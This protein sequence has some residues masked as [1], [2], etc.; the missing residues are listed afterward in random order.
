MRVFG[1]CWDHELSSACAA[2]VDRS[3][4]FAEH[5]H[6]SQTRPAGEPYVE[7]LR[8][9]I[10]VLVDGIGVTDPDLLAAAALHDVVEDTEVASTWSGPNSVTRQ[11]HW[12]RG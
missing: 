10:A 1:P 2:V 12:F 8:E 5:A 7:H 11:H 3:L 6:G 4:K 9:A